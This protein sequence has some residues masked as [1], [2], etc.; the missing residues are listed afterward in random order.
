[1]ENRAYALA[2]GFFTVM[3]VT[4]TALAFWWFEG[5]TDATRDYVVVTQQNV[6]GL[7]SQAQVR[8]R[9]IRVGKVYALHIDPAE[10]RNILIY[11]RIKDEVPVTR[12]TVAKLGYQGVTGIAHL[13]LEDTGR[14]TRPLVGPD[15]AP[16]RIAMIPSLIEE[17]GDTGAA[18][19]RQ[20][21]DLVAS[22]NQLVGAE[23]RRNVARTLDNVEAL[24]AELRPAV[25]G[26]QRLVA[27]AEKAASDDNVARI[28]ATLAHTEASTREAAATVAELRRLAL[29]LQA[30]AAK[31]DRSVEE[32][33]PRLQDLSAEA[34]ANARQLNR[35]LQL[36]ERSPQSVVFGPPPGAPG[37]GEPGFVAP[38][39]GQP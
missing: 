17:I 30:L 16:P 24:S 32:S 4:A 37:P 34:A 5:R 12:G 8:F 35:V 38:A 6:N 22:L 15:G 20:V 1:M 10:P 28:G 33:A 36:L 2:A 3:L 9:G 23:N 29:G 21:R 19:L 25:A 26:L 13:A 27:Q 14:D 31:L 11:I 7:S 39:K 18:T